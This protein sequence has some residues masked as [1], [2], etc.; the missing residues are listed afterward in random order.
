MYYIKEGMKTDN[1][2]LRDGEVTFHGEWPSERRLSFQHLLEH[3]ATYSP[4]H[5]SI[6]FNQ[7]FNQSINHHIQSFNHL[8]NHSIIIFNQS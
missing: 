6:I 5:H 3:R 8:I 7:A 2:R 4:I 1:I